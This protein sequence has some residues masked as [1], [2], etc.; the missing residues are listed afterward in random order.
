MTV[1]ASGMTQATITDVMLNNF[2]C[3]WAMLYP[4]SPGFLLNYL[5]NH[6]KIREQL[7]SLNNTISFYRWCYGY[8]LLLLQCAWRKR[9]PTKSK[10]SIGGSTRAHSILERLRK[11][12]QETLFFDD[13][14]S[15]SDF[16]SN[17]FRLA[18][19]AGQITSLIRTD[20]ILLG[21]PIPVPCR[22]PQRGPSLSLWLRCH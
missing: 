21:T 9:S 4:G 19:H 18:C 16:H 22:D 11:Q 12:A 10:S 3:A 15:K 7:V 14:E 8:E 2:L 20:E 17:P 1:T 5:A 13:S 6:D